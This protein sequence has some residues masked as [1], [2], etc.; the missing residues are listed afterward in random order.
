MGR[1]ADMSGIFAMAVAAVLAGAQGTAAMPRDDGTGLPAP[2]SRVAERL[3]S[4]AHFA[5]EFSGDRSERD[6]Q[7]NRT[8]TELRCD[9]VEREA[10]ELRRRYAG[11]ER[12][13]QALAEPEP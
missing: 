1:E 2:V 12:I 10:A 7:I 3:A 11:D 13:Q 4:C 9:T 6:A 5:G 8:L